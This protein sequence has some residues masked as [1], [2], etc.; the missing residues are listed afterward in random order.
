MLGR[1]TEP[2]QTMTPPGSRIPVPVIPDAARVMP[3]VA[4]IE[5]GKPIPPEM[6]AGMLRAAR[7]SLAA[8]RY[9]E[10][11]AAYQAVSSA[12]RRTWTRWRTSG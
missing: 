6:L 7:A 12:T 1:F 5:P 11:I 8:E 2:D 3:P 10:A 9:S 4:G